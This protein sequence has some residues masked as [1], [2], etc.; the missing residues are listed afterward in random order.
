MTDNKSV[1]E[2]EKCKFCNGKPCNN[3]CKSKI[4]QRRCPRCNVYIEKSSNYDKHLNRKTPCEINKVET[5]VLNTTSTINQSNTVQDVISSK[6]LRKSIEEIS[7]ME[8]E[9][10]ELNE[11]KWKL[12]KETIEGISDEIYLDEIEMMESRICE[13]EK[14]VEERDKRIN[15]MKEFYHKFYNQ[16]K[17]YWESGRGYCIPSI[18]SE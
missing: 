10:K 2:I 3:N 5:A 13:L 16:M 9:E 14:I 12:I 8:M 4:L 17:P 15:K 6:L 18:F 7:N 1:N 11:K